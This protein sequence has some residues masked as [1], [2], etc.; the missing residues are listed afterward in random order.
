MRGIQHILVTTRPL[1]PVHARKASE[2]DLNLNAGLVLLRPSTATTA[3]LLLW[4]CNGANDLGVAHLEVA[5]SI[6]CCLCAHLS[7]Q[8]AQLV[9]SAAVQTQMRQ[10]VGR[11]IER[12]GEECCIFTLLVIATAVKSICFALLQLGCD[13]FRGGACCFTSR[14]RSGDRPASRVGIATIDLELLTAIS[15]AL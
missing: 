8:T 10:Y 12:H 7:L 2:V 13:K 11:S 1:L 6:C 14:R 4:T 5:G 3:F 9:P 15:R